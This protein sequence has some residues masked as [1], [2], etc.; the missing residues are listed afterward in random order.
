[1]SDDGR[2]LSIARFGI[3]DIRDNGWSAPRRG[4]SW[5]WSDDGHRIA[6]FT[7]REA[8]DAALKARM[9][10]GTLRCPWIV[11]EFHKEED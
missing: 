1:M 7:T 6:A 3:R 2:L 5:T 9:G 4:E 8:A 11:D 10:Q